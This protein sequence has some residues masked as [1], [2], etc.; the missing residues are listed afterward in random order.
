VIGQLS[1]SFFLFKIASTI[2]FSAL[3]TSVNKIF[4]FSQ[5]ITHKEKNGGVM[6]A[7]EA[8]TGGAAWDGRG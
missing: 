6:V 5:N 2:F 8:A 7:E 1:A 4:P 3:I